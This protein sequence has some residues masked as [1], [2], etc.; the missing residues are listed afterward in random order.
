MISLVVINYRSAGLAAEAIRSARAATREPL[1]V[2]VVENTCNDGEAGHLRPSVDVLITPSRNLGYAAGINAGRAACTGDVIV[3]SNPDVVFAAGSIDALVGALNDRGAAVA[4]PALF[5]DDAHTWMLPPS[6][7]HTAGEK[8]GEALAS[9]N[10]TFAGVRDRRR[11][12]ARLR[13]WTITEPVEAHAISGAVMAIRAAD[14]DA[15]R[16]FDE[17][18]ALYFE[19]NDFLRRVTRSGKRIV[20][21]P[22]ARCRH[23]YNQSAGSE[24]AS[25]TLAYAESEMRYLAKWYGAR[26]ASWLK[27]AERPRVT[28]MPP[29]LDGPIALPQTNVLVEAS[30]LA[31]FETAAGHFPASATID[32]PPE[33]WQSYRSEILYLRVIERGTGQVLATYARYRS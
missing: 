29:R 1:Q 26:R 22:S 13:F 5:W 8:I 12:A 6:E 16:G 14:F 33:V 9:R 19:E 7:L 3:A 30:P 32:L 27:A 11:I 24:L 2:V 21:V 10:A 4:G 25:A 31:S 20:Y 17:G 23:L 28:A 15:V 18:F